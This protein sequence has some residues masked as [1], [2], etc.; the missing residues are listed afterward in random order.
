MVPRMDM[1][2][3]A[4]SA[5]NIFI[6]DFALVLMLRDVLKHIH[7]IYVLPVMCAHQ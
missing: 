1:T 3:T 4:G 5:D 6:L 7:V 2:M